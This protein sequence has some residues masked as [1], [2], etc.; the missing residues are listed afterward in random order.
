VSD[1]HTTTTTNGQRLLAAGTLGMASVAFL[2]HLLAPRAMAEQFGWPEDRWY[3]R[4]IGAFNAGLGYGVIRALRGRPD[5]AFIA[6][7]G[8]TALLLAATRA[9][10]LASGDRTGRRNLA[11]V[12]GDLAL[13]LGALHQLRRHSAGTQAGE[14]RP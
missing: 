5:T 3:Q 14:E 4:E 2:G 12:L 10:A 1:H 6:S 11:T 13:G 7:A 8:V 9:A